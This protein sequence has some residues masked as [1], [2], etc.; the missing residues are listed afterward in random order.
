[1]SSMNLKLWMMH[2]F[3]LI[4]KRYQIFKVH[5]YWFSLCYSLLTLLL[6]ISLIWCGTLTRTFW[7]WGKVEEQSTVLIGKIINVSIKG[8]SLLIM[9]YIENQRGCYAICDSCCFEWNW[10]WPDHLKRGDHNSWECEL[11]ECFSYFGLEKNNN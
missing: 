10:F 11:K 8:L 6:C 7:S 9:F 5:S 4:S 1:M 3:R 2:A